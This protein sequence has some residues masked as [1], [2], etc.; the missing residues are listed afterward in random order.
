MN[1]EINITLINKS[2]NNICGYFLALSIINLIATL[3]ASDSQ[4]KIAFN[5]GIIDIE[6]NI[7]SLVF[8]IVN[9]RLALRISLIPA[10]KLVILVFIANLLV[11]S[12]EYIDEILSDCGQRSIRDLNVVVGYSLGGSA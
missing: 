1:Q 12:L 3:G 9:H 2:T 4:C 11:S 8:K 6:H 5:S 10:T 7:P